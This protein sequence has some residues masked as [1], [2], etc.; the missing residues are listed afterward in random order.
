MTRL[1]VNINKVATL[2]NARGENNPD[3]LRFALA[4]EA[5]GAQ[6][7]TIHPR[8][9]ERH[10]RRSDVPVLKEAV[11]TEL[12]IEGYPSEDFINLVIET[13]PAQVTLVPDAPGQLTSNHGWDVMANSEFLSAVIAR[14]KE[15]GIRV[16]VF[17]DPDSNPVS[18]SP[19]RAHAP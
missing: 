16:S 15:A 5:A 1:S 9:D 13:K 17:V 18:Y 4:C 14:F 8:P 7:I 12:N 3:L 6:G 2:R 10:I 11:T 19:L